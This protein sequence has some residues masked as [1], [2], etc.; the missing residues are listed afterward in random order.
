[1]ELTEEMI[2]Q[3]QK[4]LANAKTFDDLMGQKRSY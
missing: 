3:L 4:D 2:A 1:M